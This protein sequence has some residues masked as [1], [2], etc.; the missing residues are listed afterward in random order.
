MEKVK[1]V[2]IGAG[3]RGMFAYAP[4]ALNHPNELEFIA[5]AEPDEERRRLFA[6]K[7]NIPDE[8][9]FRSWEELLDQGRIADSALICTQDSMHFQPALKA[10]AAGYH[11]LLEKP[12]SNNVEECAALEMAAQK[13]SRLFQI[14]HVLRYT[15]FFSNIKKLL[16]TKRIGELVS[17]QHNENVGYY[18]QAHSYVRGNWRNSIE[19]SP[20]ILAKSCHDLD[21]L[22]WLAGADCSKLSSFGGLMHFRT[23]NA[24]ENAPDRC[25]DGCPV[26][27][28]CPYNALKLYNFDDGKWQTG[29]LRKAVCMEDTPEALLHALKT[30]PYGRCVYRC[31]NDVVDHQVLNIEFANGVTAAFTMCAFTKEISRTIKLMGTMGEIRGHMELNEIEILDFCTGNSET[32]KLHASELGHGGGDEG[33][34]RDFIRAVN[35][36]GDRGLSSIGKSVQSHLMAFAAEESRRNGK[37]MDMAI[38]KEE[39]NRR[40]LAKS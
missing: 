23:E 40:V 12:M 21:I 37:V 11:I 39:V 27:E 19:A 29:V 6:Q 24:P 15:P 22:V 1:A 9:C 18:H 30:G 14:C 25:S 10:L 4:Y 34:I 36:E 26:E 38:Y 17:I 35:T 2:L 31:D 3:M 20:M 13:Y 7:H 5:V 32:I 33:I 28:E 16:E 8:L